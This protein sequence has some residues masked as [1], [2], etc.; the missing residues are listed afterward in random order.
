MLKETIKRFRL[1]VYCPR[2]D[3]ATSL[4]RGMGPFAA[5]EKAEPRFEVMRPVLGPE[6]QELTWDWLARCDAVFVQR[7]WLPVHAQ[8][9]V[10]A[11]LMGLPLWV[12][13]DDDYL[14]IHPSNPNYRGFMH[15]AL[16]ET[17]QQ[18]ANLADVV[19]VTTAELARRVRDLVERGS[20]E[21]GADRKDGKDKVLVVPNACHWDLP[22]GPRHGRQRRLTWRGGASHE[23]DITSVLRELSEV[24]RLPQFCNW[25]WC[26]LGDT[27]WQVEQAMPR[28]RCLGGFGAEPWLYME[29]LQR[30]Q[31]YV[32]IVPLAN[33][34]FN[35]C[36]SNLAWLEATAAGAV[37]IAPGGPKWEEWDRPGILH[38][39]SPAEFGKVLRWTLE[40]YR[41]GRE[42]PEVA[43]SRG[44]IREELTLER[45]NG[46][47]WEILNGFCRLAVGDTAE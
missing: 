44:F 19:T 16:R 12:D 1:A 41:E 6:G 24:A 42:H 14:S 31:P 5:M 28:E 23:L 17:L 22:E 18:V 25:E 27:P 47:R 36:K 15:P 34:R 35:P 30:L 40:S 3:D 10:Q 20:G 39:E 26:F 2:G 45:V 4:V 29:S 43:A 13:W 32:H 11:K 9:C 37:V 38:Y 33:Y 7:P 8:L 46:Q 21:R